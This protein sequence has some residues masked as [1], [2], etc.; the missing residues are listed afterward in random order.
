MAKHT[1]K[2]NPMEKLKQFQKDKRE[3]L[4]AALGVLNN[5]HPDQLLV[6]VLAEG[7][8]AMYK[9]GEEGDYPEPNPQEEPTKPVSR[10]RVR[11]QV[12]PAARPSTTQR[13]RRRT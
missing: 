5:W 12:T 4:D 7:L 2:Q 1:P 6:V 10:T 3:W 13:V 8:E 11:T 9:R